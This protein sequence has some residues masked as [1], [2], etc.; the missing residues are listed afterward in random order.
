[1]NLKNKIN[2]PVYYAVLA[3]ILLFTVSCKSRKEIGLVPME[4]KSKME[5]LDL[6]NFQSPRYK[7]LSSSL[8]FSIKPGEKSKNTSA[9]GQLRIIK[10]KAIQLSLRMP[11]LNSE[12]FRVQISPDSMILIDR[13]HKLYL[14]ESL[15][16]IQASTSLDLNFYNLQDLFTNRLFIAGK[17]QFTPADY[18]SLSVEQ[19]QYNT[20]IQNRDKK[21]I[22][23]TFTSDYT[24][25]IQ[26]T[27]ITGKNETVRLLWTYNEFGPASDNQAFPMK[28]KMDLSLPQDAMQMNL[29]FSKVDVD[30]DIQIEFNIPNKY[31]QV[32]L[33]QVLKIIQSLQ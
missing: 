2:S 27:E 33:Q 19:S 18:E 6:I 3:G 16:T 10:D 8:K 13:V 24:N 5:R 21:Q 17:E 32:T 11:I 23:Y 31:E 26:S 22:Q 7:T 25:R 29:S 30:N 4:E 1:M 9:D 12:L 28:M 14:A 20:L 15:K